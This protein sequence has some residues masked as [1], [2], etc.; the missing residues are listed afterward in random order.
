MRLTP[1]AA[2]LLALLPAAAAAED[3]TVKRDVEVLASKTFAGRLTGSEGASLAADYI[4]DQLRALGAVPLEGQDDFRQGFEF[5]AGVRDLGTTLSLGG[6]ADP[7]EWSGEPYLQALSFSD[8]GDVSG[9]VVFVGY[10]LTVPPSHDV[11]YDSYAGLDVTDRIVLAL[12]YY[13]E[14]ATPDTKR[15]LAHFAGLRYKALQA[16]ERGAIGL[17][18]VTGPRSPNPGKLVPIAFDTALSGSG[19]VAASISGAVAEALFAS[20]ERTLEEAQA[21][22]DDANPHAMGFALDGLDVR[23]SVAVERERRTGYNVLGRLPASERSDD[24]SLILGAHYDHLGPEG[25]A[26]SLASGEALGSIH[27]GA[28]DNASGVA[29]VLGA[30]RLLAAEPRPRDV[31][32]AFWSGEEIGL[33][34]STAFLDGSALPADRITAYLNFDM[35]GRMEDNRL[36]IQ[37]AGT[38]PAWAGL[39]ERANVPVGFDV[40]VQDDPYLPTDSTSFNKAEVPNL[41]MFTGGHEDYHR[42]SDV[43]ERINYPDLERV[44]RF[45]ALLAGRLARLAEAPEFVSVPPSRRSSGSRDSLRAYTG[46]IPDYTSEVGGLRLS[47]VVDGGPAS[48]AG[49]REG[50]VIVDFAGQSITNVYDYT[51]A[52]DAV[53][54]DEPIT[55]VVLRDGERKELTLTPRARP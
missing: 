50:D 19:I 35:V 21:A 7:R 52:L 43:A 22:L 31:V 16:R 18:L 20:R 26:S 53:K 15:T 25:H 8:S 11:V 32:L 34:G 29:A 13:P 39:I 37:A 49:L 23:L 24:R 45:A 5:A 12:R 1:L 51:Y 4:I 54:I 14:D 2:P 47:G 30:A 40:Q 17:L 46:T 48:E 3:S 44:A 36:V 42:P 6:E 27:H 28:D 41:N 10:G 33:L 9:E 38:S 55:V